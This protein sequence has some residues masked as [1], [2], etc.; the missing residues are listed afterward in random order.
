MATGLATRLATRLSK[1]AISDSVEHHPHVGLFETRVT[2][3]PMA[4]HVPFNFIFFAGTSMQH[5]GVPC[6][7]LTI[8]LNVVGQASP[9]SASGILS[10]WGEISAAHRV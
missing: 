3:N 7:D 10:D 9:R 6:L 8:S 5:A 1:C 4:Y 2:Q